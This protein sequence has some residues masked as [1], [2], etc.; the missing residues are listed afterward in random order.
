MTDIDSPLLTFQATQGVPFK[1]KITSKKLLDTTIEV[2][3]PLPA[4]LS[5][6]PLG[7]LTISG[8]PPRAGTYTVKV[9]EKRTRTITIYV[10]A[11]TRTHP[12][13]PRNW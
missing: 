4:W 3:R 11:A 10:R 5:A 7:G 1:E 8:T 13:P 9:I 6:V 2:E 12:V